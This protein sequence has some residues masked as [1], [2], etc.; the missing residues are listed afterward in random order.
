MVLVQHYYHNEYKWLYETRP[1]VD[2][3][4]LNNWEI[5]QDF[6]DSNCIMRSIELNETPSAG[7]ILHHFVNQPK[8]QNGNQ[9]ALTMLPLVCNN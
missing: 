4:I 9:I 3:L 6:E 7:I 5:K 8:S 1:I 2:A